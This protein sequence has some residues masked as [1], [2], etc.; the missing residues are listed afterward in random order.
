MGWGKTSLALNWIRASQANLPSREPYFDGWAFARK[1]AG[2]LALRAAQG[3]TLTTQGDN[4]YRELHSDGRQN[5]WLCHMGRAALDG[6][7]AEFQQAVLALPMEFDGLTANCTTLRGETLAFGWQGPLLL[8]G[9]EQP[10]DGFKH[11]DSP[12]CEVELGAEQ[13]DIRYGDQ[14][15]RLHFT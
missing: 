15:M 7:F 12:Y 5:I 11:Y 14:L 3:L 9:Q 2:Y 10:L 13:M 4:A 8:N 1:G 6:S